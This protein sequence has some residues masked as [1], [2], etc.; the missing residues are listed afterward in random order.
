MGDHDRV[1]RWLLGLRLRRVV[2]VMRSLSDAII[3]G[4]GRLVSPNAAITF[5]GQ[6]LVEVEL[7]VGPDEEESDDEREAA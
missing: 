1:R 7:L 5:G 4:D 6:Q 2:H 3:T